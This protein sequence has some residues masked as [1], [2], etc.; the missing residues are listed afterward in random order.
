LAD[1]IYAFSPQR[2]VLGGGVAQHAGLHEAVRHKVQGILNG[3]IHS[4]QILDSIREFIVPP[5][6]GKRSGVLG[7][8]ALAVD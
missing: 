5:G 1:L 3:Y 8:I 2:I 4:P 6:L 7:A